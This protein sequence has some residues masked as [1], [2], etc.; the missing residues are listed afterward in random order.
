MMNRHRATGIQRQGQGDKGTRG[1]GDK[2]KS[3]QD[4][5][6][7]FSLSPCLFISPWICGDLVGSWQERQKIKGATVV[8]LSVAPV[9]DGGY[10]PHP[11]NRLTPSWIKPRGIS[12]PHISLCNQGARE[13]DQ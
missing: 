6:L 8:G 9:Y 13:P 12:L 11:D 4:I 3:R 7:L 10:L 1:Q 2:E 5:F